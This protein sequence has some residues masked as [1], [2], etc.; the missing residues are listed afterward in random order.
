MKV[1]TLRF[2][3]DGD[4]WDDY[5]VYAT[6]EAAE[7]FIAETQNEYGEDSFPSEQWELE[8]QEVRQ[9]HSRKPSTMQ[10]GK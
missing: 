9:W 7:A 1:Y 2:L 3:N 10:V 8:E 6:R 5:G 4:E